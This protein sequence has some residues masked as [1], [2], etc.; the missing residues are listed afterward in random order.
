VS[1]IITTAASYVA[2]LATVL[3]LFVNL[4]LKLNENKRWDYLFRDVDL[5]LSVNKNETVYKAVKTIEVRKKISAIQEMLHF[6]SDPSDVKVESPHA[7]AIFANGKYELHPSLQ[8]KKSDIFSYNLVAHIK[9]NPYENQGLFIAH[10]ISR[11]TKKLLLTVKVPSTLD[12]Q[13]ACCICNSQLYDGRIETNKAVPFVKSDDNM[14]VSW[15]INKPKLFHKYSIVFDI[16]R[17][18]HLE[19]QAEV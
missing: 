6:T 13:N 4:R 19:K 1:D 15:L 5:T 3:S 2:L 18:S 16:Q 17:D 9:Q 11:P 10:Y 12:P 8:M 14:L 7:S